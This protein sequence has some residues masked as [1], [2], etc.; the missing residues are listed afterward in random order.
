[1][2]PLHCL[3]P[4]RGLVW[5]RCPSSGDLRDELSSQWQVFPDL[6]AL[7]DLAFPTYALHFKACSFAPHMPVKGGALPGPGQAGATLLELP[8]EWWLT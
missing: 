8:W 1:M 4:L 3:V 6:L 2:L 7:P 5:H